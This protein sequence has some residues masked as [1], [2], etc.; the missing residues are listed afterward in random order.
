MLYKEERPI[1]FLF[2]FICIAS[3]GAGIIHQ[4]LVPVMRGFVYLQLHPARLLNDFS[5]AAGAGAALLNAASV[6]AAGLTLIRITNVRLSGPT[7]AAFFT[8]MGFGLFGK[9]LLNITPIILGVFL[10]AKLSGKTFSQYIIIALFGTAAGPIITFSIAEAGFSGLFAFLAGGG[11]GIVTGMLLPA[12]AVSMLQLHK[13]YNLYNIGLTCGFFA[14]FAAAIFSA[15]GLDLSGSIV[16]GTEKNHLLFYLIPALSFLFFVTAI[17]LEK[18]KSF[19]NLLKILKLPGRLP[20]DFFDMTSPAGGLLNMGLLGLMGWGYVLAVGGDLNGPVLGGILTIIGFGAFGKHVRN[21]PPVIAGVVLS[22]LLFGK[23]LA[24][25]GPILAALFATTLAP[26]AGDFG[27]ISGIA[28]GFVHLTIVERT[29]A[30]HG[31]INLY[32]NG[33]AGGLTATLFMAVIEWYQSR[34]ARR[35]RKGKKEKT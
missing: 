35:S 34:N 22:C 11:I 1:Y 3:A 10:A 24:A 26:I 2:G 32:N 7:V 18:K 23:S 8:M 29:A 17:I 13:G 12:I 31:G 30:W 16:W 27:I 14:V 5:A 9:T 25:P 19:T 20:S 6:A 21:T 28:A 4:G 33:F 15:A